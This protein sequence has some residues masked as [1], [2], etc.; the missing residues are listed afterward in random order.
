MKHFH[1]YIL[2]LFLIVIIIIS[3]L[4]ECGSRVA[5]SPSPW[6]NSFRYL[7]WNLKR[8]QFMCRVSLARRPPSFIW[9]KD[10]LDTVEPFILA[11]NFRLV[12]H[13]LPTAITTI[14]EYL[15]TQPS[16]TYSSSWSFILQESSCTL[17][18]S[19]F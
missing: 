2:A 11:A 8:Y 19:L 16:S 14:T 3:T 6:P 13:P 12:S 5:A 18:Q 1:S 9:S 7:G 4:S 17:W 15:A 10:N